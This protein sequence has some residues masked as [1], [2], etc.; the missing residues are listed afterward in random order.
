MSEAVILYGNTRAKVKLGKQGHTGDC[1][2]SE[3]AN[4]VSYMVD[5]R[6][7]RVLDQWADWKQKSN[8]KTS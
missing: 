3:V 8:R 1:S 2:G 6:A 5:S 7:Y 4:P